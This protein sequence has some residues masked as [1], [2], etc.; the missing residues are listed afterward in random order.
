MY[1]IGKMKKLILFFTNPI[2]VGILSLIGILE[3]LFSIP[4]SYLNN[5]ISLWIIVLIIGLILFALHLY[6]KLRILYYV[7]TYTS[8]SFGG[9]RTYTWKWSKTSYYTNVY[10]YIPTNINIQDTT[11]LEPNV[12]VYNFRHCITNK[13]LLQE[14]IMISLYDKVENS[15]QTNLFMQQLHNLEAHYSKQRQ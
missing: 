13:D 9:S 11:K 10:G 8:D 6:K 5:K 2:I 15:K 4:S 3:I 14:Y 12:K 7:K 1:I